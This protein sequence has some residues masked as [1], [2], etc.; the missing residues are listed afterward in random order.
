M[1]FTFTYSLSLNVTFYLEYQI[2][3]VVSRYFWSCIFSKNWHDKGLI[4]PHVRAPIFVSL[5]ADTVVCVVKFLKPCMTKHIVFLLLLNDYFSESQINCIIL[6]FHH[7]G[8]IFSIIFVI[9]NYICWNLWKFLFFW[10]FHMCPGL[11]FKICLVWPDINLFI[12]QL[13]IF[14]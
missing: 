9:M 10:Y 11:V 13:Y 14:V 3:I 4:Y 8:H 6:L 12:L 1:L 7:C 2:R 5:L